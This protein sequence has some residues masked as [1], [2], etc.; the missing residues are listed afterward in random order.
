VRDLLGREDQYH[1]VVV[2]EMTD[3]SFRMT[4]KA[5]TAVKDLLGK[6]EKQVD[7]AASVAKKS[8]K[9]NPQ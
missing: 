1:C 8:T 9:L 2:T 4:G 6:A 7:S 3:S 5:D